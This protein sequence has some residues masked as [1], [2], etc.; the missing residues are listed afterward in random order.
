MA[1]S[2][3]YEEARWAHYL[4]EEWWKQLFPPPSPPPDP[5]LETIIAEAWQ[6]LLPA[7]APPP[8]LVVARPRYCAKQRRQCML[9]AE[10]SERV[11]MAAFGNLLPDT[12][13][14][15]RKRKYYEPRPSSCSAWTACSAVA[16]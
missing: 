5:D 10:R 8:P 7:P 15:A 6:Q 2:L 16:P 13:R 12:A 9:A 11:R 3:S 4:E 1:G 14:P